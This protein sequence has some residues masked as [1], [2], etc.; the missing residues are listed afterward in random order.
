MRSIEHKDD[1]AQQR[2][3]YC[4]IPLNPPG[5]PLN[6]NPTIKIIMLRSIP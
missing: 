2:Y 3:K 5:R 6:I 4:L 1:N